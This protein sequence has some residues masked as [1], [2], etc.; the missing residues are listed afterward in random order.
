MTR[1][2]LVQRDHELHHRW[3]EDGSGQCDIVAGGVDAS[4]VFKGI[5]ALALDRCRARE[6]FWNCVIQNLQC[7]KGQWRALGSSAPPSISAAQAMRVT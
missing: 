5:Y 4:G 3:L 2:I 1:M 6:G 7:L